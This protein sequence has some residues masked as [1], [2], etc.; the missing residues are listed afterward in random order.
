MTPPLHSETHISRL[1]LGTVQWG[2]AYGI[3]NAS[4]QPTASEVGMMLQD[5]RNAGINLLDTARAYGDAEAV[6]GRLTCELGIQEDFCVVS[7]VKYS[8]GDPAES[9]RNQIHESLRCLRTSSL[10]VC[11]AHSAE[12]ALIPGVWDALLRARDGGL[13]KRLGVSVSDDAEHYLRK[14]MQLEAMNAVQIPLNV[15]DTGLVAGGMLREL[16]SSDITVF[17][18]SVFLQG[19]IAMEDTRVPD[20]LIEVLPVKQQLRRLA[21]EWGRG[22]LELALQYPLSLPE[23]DCVVVGCET[24]EQLQQNL[25]WANRDALT[26]EQLAQLTSLPTGLPA[27]ITKPWLWPERL[28]G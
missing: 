27:W 4:G 3:A 2:M 21:A 16:G 9:I 7:K 18:R 17:V 6:I 20:A 25:E 8:E 13:V 1:G 19:L 28:A 5:A 26:G 11:L 14:A 22:L 24:R 23:V 12:Q 10:P 15:L